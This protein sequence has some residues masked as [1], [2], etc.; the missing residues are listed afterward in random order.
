M[1]K[2]FHFKPSTGEAG[3]CRAQKGRCPFGSEDLHFET[4]AEARR[5]YEVQE[6]TRLALEKKQAQ[7]EKLFQKADGSGIYEEKIDPS[8][9]AFYS[10]E[11][12]EANNF[13]AVK[14]GDTKRTVAQRLSEWRAMGPLYANLVKVD[15]F[16]ASFIDQDGVKI[17]V[18]DYNFHKDLQRRGFVKAVD[19]PELDKCSTAHISHEF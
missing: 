10:P 8:I 11:F 5:A 14:V 6:E 12:N 13:N 2:R 9:Y 17:Y 1:V 15:S 19:L 16:H 18:R 3:L 7:S 4:I